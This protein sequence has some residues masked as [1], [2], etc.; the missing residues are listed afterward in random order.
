MQK[1]TKAKPAD[2][3]ADEREAMKKTRELQARQLAL[4]GM[5]I[6]RDAAGVWEDLPTYDSNAPEDLELFGCGPW[7]EALRKVSEAAVIA[8]NALEWGDGEYDEA[9]EAVWKLECAEEEAKRAARK[10]AR[11][12]AR[13]AKA[14]KEGGAE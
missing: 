5:K 9:N 10:A 14:R 8:N 1:Q 13:E 7:G 4:K 2:A 3:R 11:K 12:A 6:L